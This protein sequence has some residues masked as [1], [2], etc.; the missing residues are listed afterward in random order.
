MVT[1]SK[2]IIVPSTEANKQIETVNS[3]AVKYEHG[4]RI[5]IGK[6]GR[7]YHYTPEGKLICGAKLRNKSDH[8]RCH[9]APLKG[10]N[11]CRIHGG[12]SLMGTTASNFKHGGYAKFVPAR[13]ADHY[14]E[15]MDDEK[16]LELR[17]DIALYEVRIKDLLSRVESGEAGYY[18]KRIKS[19][20]GSL[21]KAAQNNDQSKFQE[22]LTEL[23]RL[24]TQ[25][26]ADYAAW[27]DLVKTIGERRKLVES[28]RKRLVEMKQM[29]T[30][31]QAMAMLS[32]VINVIQKHVKD[33]Q[34]LSAI[35]A[36]INLYINRPD[37]VHQR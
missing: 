22:H 16:L 30:A 32:Y 20:Y 19:T 11:R 3:S 26:H 5:E 37:N 8:V 33:R 15:A 9:Q 35:S 24:I 31:E 1:N 7:K 29:M 27:D 28:E 34:I 14:L 10:R 36:D 4:L 6:D 13:M 17:R 21:R 23:G 18:W 25:G 2:D 12:K